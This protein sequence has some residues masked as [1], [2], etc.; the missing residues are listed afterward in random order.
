MKREKNEAKDEW[1]TESEKWN[2][3][4][5]EFT[6]IDTVKK[7]VFYTNVWIKRE[8]EIERERKREREKF[9]QTK[10]QISDN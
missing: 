10:K 6:W 8:E 1:S 9:K 2:E 3:I 4:E 7:Y 5:T